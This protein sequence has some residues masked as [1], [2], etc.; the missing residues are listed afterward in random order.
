MLKDQRILSR[1][2][3]ILERRNM[4]YVHALFRKGDNKIFMT[5]IWLNS[6]IFWLEEF[7]LFVSSSQFDI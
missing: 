4:K 7:C 5:H 3:Q 2:V 6:Y 1:D